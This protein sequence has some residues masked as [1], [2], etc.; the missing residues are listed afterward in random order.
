MQQVELSRWIG[1]EVVRTILFKNMRDAMKEDIERAMQAVASTGKPR[2]ERLTRKE[3]AKPQA[4]VP[5][6]VD[7]DDGAPVQ[8]QQ[9]EE[10]DQTVSALLS[11]HDY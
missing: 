6:D 11:V 10:P 9:E 5:M 1:A 2:P 3:Q 4:A 8:Q 7:E